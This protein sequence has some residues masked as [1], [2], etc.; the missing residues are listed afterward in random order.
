MKL[1]G[2]VT[3]GRLDMEAAGRIA[4]YFKRVKN[5]DVI[6][7]VKKA[8]SMDTQNFHAYYRA[9][10]LPI[11]AKEMGYPAGDYG[12]A[13]VVI[14]DH[15]ASQ[16][17]QYRDPPWIVNKHGAMIPG[18]ARSTADFGKKEFWDW[19]DAVRTWSDTFFGTNIP[20]PKDVLWAPEHSEE[21]PNGPQEE[22]V[23]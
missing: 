16:M 20:D 2:K 18:P 23:R 11:I 15:I 19:I 13:H 5:A 8:Q 14:R 17:E 7:E 1:Q 9:V 3:D 10:V 12:S 6:I 22:A 21:P 4:S